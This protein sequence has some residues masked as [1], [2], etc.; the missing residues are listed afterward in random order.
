MEN[1]TTV[2]SGGGRG[3][4]FGRSKGG[5]SGLGF[6][7]RGSSPSWPYVG[8]GRGGKPRCAYYTSGANT[9]MGTVATSKEQELHGL[10]QQ[11][12]SLSSQL[13]Q[14]KTRIDKLQSEE[15]KSGNN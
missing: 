2:F 5:G 14:L 1:E 11:S 3:L 12:E 15:N 4:G 9:A 7:F 8:R 10:R 6:A 13:E